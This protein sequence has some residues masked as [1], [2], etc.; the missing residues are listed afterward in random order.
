MSCVSEVMNFGDNPTFDVISTYVLD[1][2]LKS[3]LVY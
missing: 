3:D 1:N 2:L